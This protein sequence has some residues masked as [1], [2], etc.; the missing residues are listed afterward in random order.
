MTKENEDVYIHDAV[1][2][3]N[4]MNKNFDLFE[5]DVILECQ[6]RI[7]PSM[8]NLRYKPVNLLTLKQECV[9]VR[10]CKYDNKPEYLESNYSYYMG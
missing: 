5:Q 7:R 9:G 10:N 2:T 4:G 3:T 1:L 6:D 8:L